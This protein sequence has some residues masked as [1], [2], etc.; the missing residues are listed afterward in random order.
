MSA[1]LH[2]G[3][4]SI[5]MVV[6]ILA[7]ALIL[8]SQHQ[9]DVKLHGDDETLEPVSSPVNEEKYM[10]EY[11][12]SFSYPFSHDGEH[13]VVFQK[14]NNFLLVG[15]NGPMEDQSR[16]E[17]VM[18]SLHLIYGFDM[19]DAYTALKIIRNCHATGDT[20]RN[21]CNNFRALSG[22]SENTEVVDKTGNYLPPV[23]GRLAGDGWKT[24]AIAATRGAVIGIQVVRAAEGTIMF[25]IGEAITC[26]VSD[27]GVSNIF[28]YAHS[29]I[30]IIGKAKY[31]HRA[32]SNEA[33]K[34]SQLTQSLNRYLS[35]NGLVNIILQGFNLDPQCVAIKK[36]EGAVT[37]L[38]NFQ[39]YLSTLPQISKSEADY[40]VNF[41]A[42]KK[43]TANKT[44]EAIPILNFSFFDILAR[45]TMWEYYIDAWS[46]KYYA[47]NNFDAGLY[48]SSKSDAEQA[49]SK[50]G[51]LI[52]R[53]I[54][55]TD[56]A[57]WAI[58]VLLIIIFLLCL[59][60]TTN[61][62]N[63]YNSWNYGIR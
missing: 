15:P 10:E 4:V 56:Y 40:S 35:D 28:D 16:S 27:S 19:P 8:Y 33:E 45:P 36:G 18:Q 11:G 37:T 29:E 32:Y 57:I 23:A 25:E 41:F 21:L 30:F 20:F 14:D 53:P 22:V 55:S 59:R 5:G 26:G 43:T 42:E 60:T 13:Y 62:T 49:R 2:K 50:Y 38:Q 47:R 61:E 52:D 7:L 48:I 9:T 44:I 12:A 17:L 24:N 31:K 6:I 63:Y 39:T 3:M 54:S 46:M 1:A 51:A 34:L 58:L